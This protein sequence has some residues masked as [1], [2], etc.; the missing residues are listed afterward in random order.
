MCGIQ[1]T[2]FKDAKLSFGRPMTIAA[3]EI[4]SPSEYPIQFFIDSI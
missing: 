3:R 4:I 2:Y 1:L